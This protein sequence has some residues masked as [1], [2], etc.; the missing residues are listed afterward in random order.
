MY[1]G[2]SVF[3]VKR[4]S[5]LERCGNET[6]GLHKSS[7]VD[8]IAFAGHMS[9]LRCDS[10]VVMKAERLR[11]AEPVAQSGLGGRISVEACWCF[12][13]NQSIVSWAC[14]EVAEPVLFSDPSLEALSVASTK[15]LADLGVA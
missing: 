14:S 12:T 4:S 8:G 3:H 13:W 6:T 2:G 9:W 7:I 1:R 10:R 11:P 5:A 15:S